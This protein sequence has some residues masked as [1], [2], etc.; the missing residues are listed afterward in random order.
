M[1]LGASKPGWDSALS[2]R[3]ARR[4]FDGVQL[5]RLAGLLH[6]FWRE[7]AYFGEGLHWLEVA[8]DL[9]REAPMVITPRRLARLFEQIARVVRGDASRSSARD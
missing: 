5:I 4:G 1:T 7:H 2:G 3:S 6:V 8:L 9:G